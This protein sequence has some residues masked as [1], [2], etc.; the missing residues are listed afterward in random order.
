MAHSNKD[1]HTKE[2][3]YQQQQQQP[4]KKKKKTI[5]RGQTLHE[6]ETL[7]NCTT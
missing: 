1:Q 4:K 2:A 7:S 5:Q 6:N 3:S